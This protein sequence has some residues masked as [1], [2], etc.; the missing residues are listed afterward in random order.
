[1]DRQDEEDKRGMIITCNTKKFFT[2]RWN[3]IWPDTPANSGKG[4][5]SIDHRLSHERVLHRQ[6]ESHHGRGNTRTNVAAFE[7]CV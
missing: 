1:M 5:L 4:H 7:Y 3:F 2:D 6:V